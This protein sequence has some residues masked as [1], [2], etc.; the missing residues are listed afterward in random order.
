[1]RSGKNERTST[2]SYPSTAEPPADTLEQARVFYSSPVRVH[3]TLAL[4]QRGW[5]VRPHF[6]W[7]YRERG[8]CWTQTQITMD[9]YAR[10][11]LDHIKHTK[12]PRGEEWPAVLD[13]LIEQGIF[14]PSDRAQFDADFIHTQR[15]YAA[16][17]PGLAVTRWIEPESAVEL[18]VAIERAIREAVAAFGEEIE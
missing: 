6:H 16:P 1:L 2:A 7:G 8:L 13:R 11:W 10:Y 12:A 15:Q 14:D 17:R 5:E 4:R 18:A 3:R 9:G